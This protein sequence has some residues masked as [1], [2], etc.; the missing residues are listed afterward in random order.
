MAQL[1]EKEREKIHPSS[2][3]SFYQ[4]PQQIGWC[5]P[6]L[7]QVSFL[8]IVN[9]FKCL[10]ETPSHTGTEMFYQPFGHPLA[11]TDQYIKINKINALSLFMSFVFSVSVLYF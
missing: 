8:Y 11:K 5:P 4:G 3:F 10:P 9:W 2:T 1:R 7:V 6:T